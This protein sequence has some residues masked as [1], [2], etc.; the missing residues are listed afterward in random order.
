[1]LGESILLVEYRKRAEIISLKR[2]L[3][4]PLRHFEFNLCLVILHEV[5]QQRLQ[6]RF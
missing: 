3:C 4:I 5:L 6:L 2:T 1:M